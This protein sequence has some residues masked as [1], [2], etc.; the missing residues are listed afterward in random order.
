MK[1]SCGPDF[2]ISDADCTLLLR[3][4]YPV[5]LSTVPCLMRRIGLLLSVSILLMIGDRGRAVDF[6]N[7]ILPI[8][9]EKC[10]ECHGPDS[11]A[12]A[13]GLR[14]D[15]KEGSFSDL[16]GYFAIVAG[17]SEKS[18][19]VARV[20]EDDPD[21]IMPPPDSGKTLSG[22]E[23]ALLVK[24]IENGAKWE[25]HWSYRPVVRP[26]LPGEET[27][28]DQNPIDGFVGTL[29]HEKGLQANPEADRHALGRRAAL[30][31]TGL[32]PTPRELQAFLDDRG[33]GAY[34][35]Y[36]DRLIDSDHFGEHWARFWLDAARYSD[37]HGLHLDNFR[38]MWLYRDWVVN[39]YNENLPFDQFT[40]QQLAGDLLPTPTRSQKI[41]TGF[42]RNNASS[43]EAGSIPEELRVR[44]MK[45]RTETMATVFLGMTTGCA[46]CHDHKYDPISQKE[47]Y[48]LGA[49][50]IIPPTRR[51]TGICGIP[52]PSWWYPLEKTNRNG[53]IFSR[54]AR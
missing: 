44:Y 39:A 43:S 26:E 50:L 33:S 2:R 45:D 27:L 1:Q 15:T 12:R 19:L 52:I 5:R 35:R 11:E 41:A 36:V 6:G 38:E 34:E 46:S 54:S 20:H 16:G 42:L 25:E 8:L 49:F 32:P 17:D 37:T 21:L 28:W 7:E 29:H 3:P 31:I 47:Y 40:I 48:Q 22:A 18:E 24:W 9:A 4:C 10:F 14:L 13:A 53:V 23:K 30:D 51:W